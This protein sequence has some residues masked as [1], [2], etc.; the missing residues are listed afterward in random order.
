VVVGVGGGG[1]GAGGGSSEKQEKMRRWA[2]AQDGES[3]T[4]WGWTAGD[5]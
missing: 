2:R 3:Q 1:G 4:S 5:V